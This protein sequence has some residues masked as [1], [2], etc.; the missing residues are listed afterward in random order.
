MDEINETKE[1][2]EIR[3]L[4]KDQ[5]G[6]LLPFTTKKGKYNVI[7]PGDPI[8]IQRWTEYEK[9]KI[10]MGTGKTFTALIETLEKVEKM[11]GA[12]KPFADI[13]VEAILTVNGMRR[14]IIELSRER[15]NQALYLASIF[16]W[17]EG[18]DPLTWDINRAT[19]Y[20]EDWA[21][22]GLNEQDFFSFALATVSGFNEIFKRLSRETA[23]QADALSGIST[24]HQTAGGKIQ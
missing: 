1:T 19:E 5:S 14:G 17:R 18:D 4:P 22:E 23:A 24:F 7:R 13:R 10:V 8:G 20:I 3:N 6:V 11:L 12:D 15:Y 21:G 16:I 2:K 9:L